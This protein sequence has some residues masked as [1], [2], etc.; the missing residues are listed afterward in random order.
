MN[1][2]ERNYNVF[3][4]NFDFES[5]T[6]FIKVCFVVILFYP[7]LNFTLDRFDK[8]N[9][10]PHRNKVY[11]IKNLIKTTIMFYITFELFNFILPNIIFRNNW[12]DKI[13]RYYG[14]FYVANDII[15]LLMVPKLPYTTKFHHITTLLLYTISCYVSFQNKTVKM[16]FCYTLFSCIPFLVNLFLAIRFFHTKGDKLTYQ[17]E[18]INSVIDLCRII[19]YNVYN[20]TCIINW[21]IHI[22]YFTN[23]FYYYTFGLG[24][25]LY[26][27]ILMPIVN[28]DLILLS[29]LKDKKYNL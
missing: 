13:L 14:G 29:W 12:D 18:N 9:S 1:F 26:T 25:L 20:L 27:I 2:I 15:G 17:E 21:S 10:L 16:L 8:Y 23:C 19:S 22:I 4:N 11:I 28:D 3:Y 7:I 5:Y 6:H 24:E